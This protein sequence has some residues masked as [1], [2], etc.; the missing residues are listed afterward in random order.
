MPAVP[1][2]ATTAVSLS[3]NCFTNDACVLATQKCCIRIR[4]HIAV[5]PG[6]K[7][8]CK[9]YRTV[10][11]V[12]FLDRR[13]GNAVFG[14]WAKFPGAHGVDHRTVDSVA[15]SRENLQVGNLAGGVDGDVEHNFTLRAM[16]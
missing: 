10:V 9:L 3:G 16:G 7:L 15:E 5:P 11:E 1:N 6:L 8:S 12:K 2:S 14:G 4:A 13:D